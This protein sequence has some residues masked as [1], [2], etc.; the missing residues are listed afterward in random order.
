MKPGDYTLH[1]LIQKAKDL[2]ID[3]EDAMNVLCEVTVQTTKETT[4]EV[5]DV[6]STT[7]VNFD[8]HVFIELMQ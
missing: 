8:S 3:D 1:L 2:D 7:V 6:T 5:K 4:K